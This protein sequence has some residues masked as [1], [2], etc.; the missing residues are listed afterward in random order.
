MARL[1]VV[2]TVAERV[3]MALREAR[4]RHHAL[5]DPRKK[6][7]AVRAAVPHSFPTGDVEQML[8]EIETG[9][10]GRTGR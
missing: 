10:L 3:R 7:A 6:L 2:L 9:Y 1:K 8:S 5:G 4:R